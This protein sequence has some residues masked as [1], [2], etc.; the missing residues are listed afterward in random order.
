[1]T[2]LDAEIAPRIAA[3]NK[4]APPLPPTKEAL[5]PEEQAI[6]DEV[7]AMEFERWDLKGEEG[8]FLTGMWTIET[9]NKNAIAIRVALMLLKFDKPELVE[10][11]RNLRERSLKDGDEEE[12]IALTNKL[13]EA[14]RYFEGGIGLIDTALS[15]LAIAEVVMIKEEH[16]P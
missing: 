1:M 7:A 12:P 13:E 11:M 9:L 2:N 5:T 3:K 16:A 8:K 4:Y 10:R 14:R 6:A 15:R